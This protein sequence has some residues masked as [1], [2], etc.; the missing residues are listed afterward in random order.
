MRQLQIDRRGYVG[1]HMVVALLQASGRKV[2]YTE[3]EMADDKTWD[4]IADGL[5]YEIK[6]ATIG[7][8]SENFQHEN[9]YDEH[10]WDGIIFVD[11]APAEIYISCWAA[12][13]I[14]WDELHL[15]KNEAF[16][17]WDTS[18]KSSHKFCVAGNRVRTL[19]DFERVFR[20]MEKFI[21]ARMKK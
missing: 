18:L 1:E 21:H 19:D 15:R 8:N 14:N 2:V 3:G 9:I 7:A 10:S 13:E 11:I 16:Y 17:K 20:P 5:R 12:H 6:T 4:V